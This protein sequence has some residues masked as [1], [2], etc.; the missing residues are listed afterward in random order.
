MLDYR[1]RAA[2]AK[3]VG[4]LTDVVIEATRTQDRLP[5]GFDKRE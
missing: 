3:N 1:I 2:I 4:F 5:D